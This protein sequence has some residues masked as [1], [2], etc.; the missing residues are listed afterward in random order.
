MC[1]TLHAA[2]LNQTVA[3]PLHFSIAR[4]PVLYGSKD[5][6]RALIAGLNHAVM[7]P[8]AFS[9]RV[10]NSRPSEICEMSGNFWLRRLQDFHEIADA[11]FVVP[12]QVQ[13]PQSRSIRKGTEQQFHIERPGWLFHSDG[14]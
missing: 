7:H 6:R 13:Q 9:S 8:F 5:L 2:H 12:E 4:Q 1:R 14:F 11:Y 3:I 10:D